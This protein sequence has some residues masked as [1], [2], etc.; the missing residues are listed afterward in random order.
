[1]AHT[2]TN[3]RQ[4]RRKDVQKAADKAN[5]PKTVTC[6]SCGKKF[7]ASNTGGASVGGG[8]AAGGGG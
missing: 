7:S 8:A 3:Q 2:A 1:M 4:E 5:A 6:P